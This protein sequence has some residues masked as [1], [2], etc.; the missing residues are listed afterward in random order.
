MY[1]FNPPKIIYL[2]I[3]STIFWLF[4]NYKH[5]DFKLIRKKKTKKFNHQNLEINN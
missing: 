3:K 1:K 2:N 5:Y 4:V